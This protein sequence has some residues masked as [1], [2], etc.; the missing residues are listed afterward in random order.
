MK[1]NLACAIFNNIWDCSHAV[2]EAEVKFT[3]ASNK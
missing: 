1:V 3:E 2:A